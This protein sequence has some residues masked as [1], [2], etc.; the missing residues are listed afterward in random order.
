MQNAS[1]TN[2]PHAA[3]KPVKVILIEDHDLIRYT[4]RRYLESSGRY[5]V[6]AE[7]HNV[8]SALTLTK[9]LIPDLSIVDIGLPGKNGFEYVAQAKKL[10]PDLRVVCLSMYEEN[11]KVHSALELGA[12]GY[13]SKSSPPELFLASLSRILGGETVIP[14]FHTVSENLSKATD[15]LHKLSRREREIFLLLADGD[16]NRVIAKKLSISP[17]TVETHRARVIKKLGFNSTTDLVRFAI[18]HHLLTA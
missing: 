10:L 8:D 3:A 18:R 4:L 15:P 5:S 11:Q 13:I 1:Y 2:L 14:N 6:V 7:A 17:R 9:E 16:P 12:V